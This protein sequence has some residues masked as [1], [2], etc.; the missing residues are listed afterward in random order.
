MSK[1]DMTPGAQIPRTDAG[2]QTAVTQALSSAAYRDG[3]VDDFVKN[4][5]PELPR[6]KGR[7]DLFEPNL[8]EA[9]SKAVIARTL[10][11]ARKP[12]VPSF[13][14]DPGWSSNTAWPPRS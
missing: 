3:S 7:F 2:P 11:A 1:L 8:G 6:K 5:Q 9:F 4:V 12:I 13:G 14:T 10:G